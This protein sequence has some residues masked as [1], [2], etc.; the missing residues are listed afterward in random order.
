MA[1]WCHPNTLGKFSSDSQTLL[2]ILCG[3]GLH[4]L[5]KLIH[6]TGTLVYNVDCNLKFEHIFKSIQ[7]PTTFLPHAHAHQQYILPRL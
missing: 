4:C 5:R 3:F 2:D 7:V 6:N 1:I